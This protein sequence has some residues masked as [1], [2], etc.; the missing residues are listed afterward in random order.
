VRSRA[1]QAEHV[2]GRGGSSPRPTRRVLLAAAGAMVLAA[3]AAGT[4]AGA[5][6]AHATPRTDAQ[7]AYDWS[8]AQ[9]VGGGFVDGLVFSQARPGLAYARTDIG[10]AVLYH[11]VDGGA[12]FTTDASVGYADTLGFG[13]AAPGASYPAIYLAT[14]GRG[15]EYAGPAYPAD[16]R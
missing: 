9:I 16:P 11:S 8:N 4:P 13:K 3:L 15:I 2:G 6:P 12:S 7:A 5:P 1:E 14:N 10:G